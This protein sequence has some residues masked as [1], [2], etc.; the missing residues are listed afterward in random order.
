MESCY[1]KRREFDEKLHTQERSTER[2]KD[3]S[4]QVSNKRK[5]NGSLQIPTCSWD[6]LKRQDLILLI[7]ILQSSNIPVSG[8]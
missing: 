3:D 1:R 7:I 4:K 5:R 8:L 2:E 6:I